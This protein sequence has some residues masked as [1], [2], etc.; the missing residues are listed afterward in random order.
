MVH[1]PPQK[2][3]DDAAA[4]FRR[5]RRMSDEYTVSGSLPRTVHH[6]PTRSRPSIADTFATSRLASKWKRSVLSNSH[7]G[8]GGGPDDG[9]TK[10]AE[11]IDVNHKSP[12]ATAQQIAGTYVAPTGAPAFKPGRGDL[13]DDEDEYANTT[14]MGRR[15][16]TEPVLEVAQAREV[17]SA[18]CCLCGLLAFSHYFSVTGF[19]ACPT[20]T[21]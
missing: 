1:A 15:E 8:G 18:H 17:S 12:F 21:D 13:H 2:G 9:P 10:T 4:E 19:V 7:F 3:G 6:S 5:L 16:L 20:A 11:L 14:L